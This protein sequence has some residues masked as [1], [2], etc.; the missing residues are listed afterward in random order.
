LEKD[1]HIVT[2]AG[3][4]MEA[5]QRMRE[6]YRAG[7]PQYDLVLTDLGMPEINGLQLI[8]AIRAAGLTMP[9]LLVTGWGMELSDDV[10]RHAGAQGV[11]SKPFAAAELRAA[12][13]AAVAATRDPAAEPADDATA[14]DDEDG[15]TNAAVDADTSQRRTPAASRRR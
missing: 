6:R 4:G 7:E 1:G 8:S 10:I 5:M 2:P 14:R 15:D 13:A 12:M 3:S 11:L 9:C